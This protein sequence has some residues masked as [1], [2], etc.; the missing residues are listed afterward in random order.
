MPHETVAVSVYNIHA[1]CHFVQSHRLN[2]HASLA[3]TCHM[4]FWQNDWDRLRATVVTRGGT[5]T[6]IRIS[7]E[8]WPWRRKFSC[9]SCRDLNQRLFSHKSGALTTELSLIQ[10]H[11]T[12]SILP[13]HK[14]CKSVTS[15]PVIQVLA[16]KGLWHC[17]NCQHV[18]Q[19][20]LLSHYFF[21][22]ILLAIYVTW[23][24]FKVDMVKND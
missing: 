13:M 16:H 2:V 12:D 8:S 6:E 24:F 7:T 5:D 19:C 1:P 15:L 4:H 11:S 23:V 22:F 9:C 20:I 14:H 18:W 21:K 17:K 10:F 3:V